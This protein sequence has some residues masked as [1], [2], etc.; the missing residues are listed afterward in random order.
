MRILGLI[1]ARGG[2]KGI[3]RKNIKLLHGKELIKYSI[4]VGL[5]CELLSE[6]MVST[7][8]KEIAKIIK[9]MLAIVRDDAPW[10]FAFY[11][12]TFRLSHV[13]NQNIKLNTMANNTLKYAKIDSSKR[14]KL[15]KRWNQPKWWPIVILFTL[16]RVLMQQCWYGQIYWHYGQ[17]FVKW[18][19]A[20]LEPA[21]RC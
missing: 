2:S 11:P 14:A 5:K 21:T 9:K 4:E 10:I 8:D 12:K 16:R 15:Q 17:R 1:P 6:I 13:W 18:A 19:N 20:W 7:D 3:P